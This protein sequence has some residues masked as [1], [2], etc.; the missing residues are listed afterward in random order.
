MNE[1]NS[2]KFV[3]GEEWFDF[4]DEN[5]DTRYNGEKYDI[6]IGPVA[7]DNTHTAFTLFRNHAITKQEAINRL[8]PMKLSDQV[9]FATDKSLSYLMYVGSEEV[10]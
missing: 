7:N 5:R 1:L 9:F 6:I 8:M 4:V 3:K 2:K 10:K